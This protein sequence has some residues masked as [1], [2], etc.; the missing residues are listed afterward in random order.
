M[1]FV[2]I[3]VLDLNEGVPPEQISM[4]SNSSLGF[5]ALRQSIKFHMCARYRNFSV[6]SPIEAVEGVVSLRYSSFK[7]SMKRQLLKLMYTVHWDL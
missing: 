7:T 1:D 4:H 3:S 2:V 6:S 5:K